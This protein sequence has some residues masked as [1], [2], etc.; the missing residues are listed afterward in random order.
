MDNAEKYYP[1]FLFTIKKILAHTNFNITSLFFHRI[2]W[3][4]TE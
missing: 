3:C 2:I 4:D 1:F